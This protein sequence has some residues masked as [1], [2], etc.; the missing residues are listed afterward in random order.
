MVV[1]TL[2]AKHD[3]LQKVASTRDHVKAISEFVWNALDADA[4]CTSV[5]FVRNALGGLEG[6][7]IRDNGTGISKDRA[8][9]DF[10]SLGES[11]KLTRARTPVL[12]RAI[13]GKEGQGRLRFFSLA[14]RAHWDTVYK[15]NKKLF[16]LKIDIDAD[17]L[18]VSNVS[19]LTPADANDETGTVVQLAPLK[20]TLIGSLVMKRAQNSIQSSHRTFSSTPTPRSSM[21]ANLLIP[22]G[23]LNALMSFRSRQLSVLVGL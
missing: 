21:T 13:H 10:E 8:E 18:E 5:E 15:Q 12:A 6:I 14:R 23:I 9:H 19:D 2:K 3:H 1:L 11:W 4:E 16:K 22:S 7:I 20:E 17:R